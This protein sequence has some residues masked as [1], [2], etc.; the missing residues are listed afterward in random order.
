[1][2]RDTEELFLRSL[3]TKQH[4]PRTV[5]L[6]QK[7]SF[8][9]NVAR[10]RR[11]INEKPMDQATSPVDG[12]SATENFLPATMRLDI[13]IF[14]VCEQMTTVK[15]WGG[16]TAGFES[17]VLFTYFIPWARAQVEGPARTQAPT[18]THIKRVLLSNNLKLTRHWGNASQ[19]GFF[20]I[21]FWAV[22]PPV[23]QYIHNNYLMLI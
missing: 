16:A 15:T 9:D 17:V 21:L 6:Q 12:L 1:M 18:I 4:C 11:I 20:R 19:R 3:R 7:F 13:W 2:W 5:H 14:L 8:R 22:W 23:G 10:H